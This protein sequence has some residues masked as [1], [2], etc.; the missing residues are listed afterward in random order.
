MTHILT[1]KTLTPQLFTHKPIILINPA[2][3]HKSDHPTE[4]IWES[5]SLF[6]SLSPDFFSVLSH[7]RGTDHKAEHTVP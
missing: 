3:S 4:W 5:L 1:H 7:L 6:H 2:L